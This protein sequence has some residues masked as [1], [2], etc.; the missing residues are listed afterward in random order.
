MKNCIEGSQLWE[1][2]SFLSGVLGNDPGIPGR[3]AGTLLYH[4]S[5]VE[6]VHSQMRNSRFQCFRVPKML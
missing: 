6:N 3:I 2:V 1:V 5:S 4:L